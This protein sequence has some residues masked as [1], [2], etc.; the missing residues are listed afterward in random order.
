MDEVCQPLADLMNY[1]LSCGYI[2]PMMLE[3]LVTPVPK[4]DKD[5]TLPTNYRGITVLSITGK[6]LEKVLQRRTETVLSQNQS[7]LQRGFTK[8]SSSI[9]AALL[10][11]EM[12]NEAKDC[13]EPLTLVTLAAAKAFDMVWQGS[14]L[15]KIYLEGVDGCTWLTLL[16]MYTQAMSSVRWG[17]RVS[18]PFPVKQGVRQGGILSTIH[19]VVQ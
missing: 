10:I 3:G 9:N 1:I 12:Q 11:S 5:A 6:V 15:R 2:P 13:G 8:K 4:K 7:R 18:A 16:N 19:Y 17:Q 14:L